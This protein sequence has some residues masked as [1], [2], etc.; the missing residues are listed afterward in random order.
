VITHD[1]LWSYEIPN[2][3]KVANNRKN[4]HAA[5]AMTLE[6]SEAADYDRKKSALLSLLPVH[7]QLCRTELL[8]GWQLIDGIRLSASAGLS[9]FIA[10]IG[11]WSLLPNGAPFVATTSVAAGVSGF[12]GWQFVKWWVVNTSRLVNHPVTRMRWATNFVAC[13]APAKRVSGAGA[14]APPGDTRGCTILANPTKTAV[15]KQQLQEIRGKE[16]SPGEQ[17]LGATRVVRDVDPPPSDGKWGMKGVRDIPKRSPS[18]FGDLVRID[19]SPTWGATEVRA[20]FEGV[21]WRVAP[22]LGAA[23]VWDAKDF[24]TRLAAIAARF[25]PAEDYE[26]GTPEAIR[27]AR[28]MKGLKNKFTFQAVKRSLQRIGLVDGLGGKRS[29]EEVRKLLLDL[30]TGM[31]IDECIDVIT[32]LEV[33]S[34]PGKGP[35]LVCNEGPYRQVIALL[36]VSVFEDILFEFAHSASIKHQTRDGVMDSI[37]ETCAAVPEVGGKKF[38]P[39][40]VEVDQTRF[41]SNENCR[42]EEG[43]SYGLLHW[44]FDLLDHIAGHIGS[45]RLEVAPKIEKVRKQEDSCRSKLKF[46]D[47]PRWKGNLASVRLALKWIFRTSGNRRTSSGNYIQEVGCTL[48]NFTQNPEI[49]WDRKDLLKFD[50][51]FTG[52]DGQE[53]YFRF[54]AEGDD[55]LGQ[56]D[57]RAMAWNDDIIEGYKCLGLRAKLVFVVGTRSELARAEFCGMHFLVCEGKTVRKCVIPDIA[58]GLINSGYNASTA[59]DCARP[60]IIASAFYMKGISFAAVQPLHDYFVALADSW[61]VRADLEATEIS[62]FD[63][64]SK[65][66]HAKI[67]LATLQTMARDANASARQIPKDNLIRLVG[68]SIGC[69]VSAAEYSRWSSS[70]R[71]VT[72]DM[73]A[74]EVMT[75]LPR[76]LQEKILESFG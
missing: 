74:S 29:P 67:N 20:K 17:M 76:G 42:R 12:A 31:D 33:T 68:A 51:I 13:D 38:E 57:K 65:T 21:V 56:C 43:E 10:G 63:V 41:D 15:Q 3:T 36:I 71:T 54:W 48:A 19:W 25:T 66:G 7:N 72:P 11:L 22:V 70:A 39:V 37:A 35:R 6:G 46:G 18:E 14:G 30:A 5:F 28:F 16:N 64:L 27:H 62:G 34:N 24:R 23:N 47:G 60:G 59:P 26:P 32:K 55:F 52:V 73:D 69:K 53:F 61:A 4:L 58:R 1:L 44:E 75:W 9:G 45:V 2:A 50:W 49:F 40:M 8:R